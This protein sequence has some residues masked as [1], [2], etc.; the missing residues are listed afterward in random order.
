MKREKMTTTRFNPLSPPF[1][2]LATAKLAGVA[3]DPN[4]DANL[5]KDSVPVITLADKCVRLH[6]KCTN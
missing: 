3:V 1:A 5:S 2:V 4:A 6:C